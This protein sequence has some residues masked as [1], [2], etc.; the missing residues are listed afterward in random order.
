M[1]KRLKFS[2]YQQFVN[3]VEEYDSNSSSSYVFTTIQKKITDNER[4]MP[5]VRTTYQGSNKPVSLQ[6]YM[7]QN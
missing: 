4:I 6:D 3:Y 7:N 2:K 5:R 1:Y